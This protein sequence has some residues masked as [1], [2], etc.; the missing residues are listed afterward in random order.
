M[1]LRCRSSTRL[2][3]LIMAEQSW[4]SQDHRGRPQETICTNAG[5]DFSPDIARDSVG[6]LLRATSYYGSR[7]REVQ[8]RTP[9]GGNRRYVQT[10]LSPPSM[11]KPG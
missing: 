4:H 9:I 11:L 1:R 7:L 10:H 6:V 8:T 2:P 3:S 5:S